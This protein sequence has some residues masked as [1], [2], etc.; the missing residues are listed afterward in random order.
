MSNLK[1]KLK[2]SECLLN[3]YYQEKERR[4]GVETKKWIWS[5]WKKCE[6]DGQVEVEKKKV[7]G[8]ETRKLIA[9]DSRL[10]S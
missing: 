2:W 8:D 5:D 10:R 1:L 6:I 7:G 3:D 4:R 9:N